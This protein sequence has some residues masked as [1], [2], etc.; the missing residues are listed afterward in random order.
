M[1]SSVLWCVLLWRWA[2]GNSMQVAM[3]PVSL[4]ARRFSQVV[5]ILGRL[6]LVDGFLGNLLTSE[7][8]IVAILGFDHRVCNSVALGQSAYPSSIGGT[9]VLLMPS[10]VNMDRALIDAIV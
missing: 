9:L 2:Q 6:W 3:V 4:L 7:A 8:N 1:E 10:L 5:R